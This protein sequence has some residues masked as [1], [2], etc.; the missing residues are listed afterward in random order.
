MHFYITKT[1][2]NTLKVTIYKI[3]VPQVYQKCTNAYLNNKSKIYTNKRKRSARQWTQHTHTDVSNWLSPRRSKR[4]A[5]Q[6]IKGWGE[7]CS[8][9]IAVSECTRGE[10]GVGW[11]VDVRGIGRYAGKIQSRVPLQIG[12]R[13]TSHVHDYV[14]HDHDN[15]QV[16]LFI[17][18]IMWDFICGY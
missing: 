5:V 11:N 9:E 13:M 16:C 4:A 15:L 10:R 8:E 3:S 12:I 6:G 7:G 1:E 18:F 14:A 2:H 17:I